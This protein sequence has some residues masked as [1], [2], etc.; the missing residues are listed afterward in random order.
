MNHVRENIGHQLLD[1]LHHCECADVIDDGPDF[2]DLNHRASTDGRDGIEMALRALG[3]NKAVEDHR[4]FGIHT[5]H[6]TIA[7]Q[8]GKHWNP[9]EFEHIEMAGG[10]VMSMKKPICFNCGSDDILSDAYA[11]WDSIAGAWV[12]HAAY[13]NWVCLGC[14]DQDAS[15]RWVDVEEVAA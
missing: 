12:L 3:F 14:E 5:A 8:H 9:V 6:E 7:A 11:S 2:N 10:C 15:L 1:I 4:Q 13:E